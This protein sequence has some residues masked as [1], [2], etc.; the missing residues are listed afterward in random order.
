MILALALTVLVVLAVDAAE[1]VNT[2]WP[3]VAMVL[4]LVVARI[5]DA[6]AERWFKFG[7]AVALS[8]VAGGL[9]AL[10][11]DW[12][13]GFDAGDLG[14]LGTRIT[15]IFGVAHAT[16]TALDL[17]I[18]KLTGGTADLN[19]IGAVKPDSGLGG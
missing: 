14:E 5:T 17:A 9:T 3:V 18:T 6:D 2:I 11:M 1:F 13:G 7:V 19:T 16:Y 15:A 8:I 4:P 10:G 12:S